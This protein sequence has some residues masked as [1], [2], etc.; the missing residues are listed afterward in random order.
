MHSDEEAAKCTEH[1][2][3]KLVGDCKL[4]HLQQALNVVYL[5][6]SSLDERN[7]TVTHGRQEL[8]LRPLAAGNTTIEKTISTCRTE[9]AV[10]G[11]CFRVL[12]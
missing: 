1:T 3:V 12:S 6:E 10:L 11:Y 9:S 7:L 5:L 2:R 8:H 4:Q